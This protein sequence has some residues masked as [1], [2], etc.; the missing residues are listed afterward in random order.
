MADLGQ[1]YVQIVPSAEGISGSI[2]DVLSPEAKKAG[3]SAGK[4]V[5][6][7]LGGT[8]S[9]VGSGMS[10]YVTAPLAGVGAA[11]VA[12]F[13]DVHTGLENIITKTGA[14]GETLEGMRGIMSNLATEIPTDFNTIGNAIGEVNTR[15]GSTGEELETLSGQFIKFADLNGVDVSNAI[16]SVQ[17][18]MA[19]FGLDVQDTGAFLDTLNKVG[20][21]TGVSVTQLASDLMTNAA[22]LKDMG[23]SASDAANFIGNLNKNGIDSST[24]MSGLKKAFS[25]AAAEGKPMSSVLGELQTAMQNAETDTEAYQAAL[26]LFGNRAGPAIA[27]ACRSGRLSF[28]ELGTSITDN[29]GNIETTFDSTLTPM[30]TFKTTMNTLKDT[31]AELGTNL[32]TTLQPAIQTIADVIAKVSEKWQSL[33]PET[34]DAIVKAALIVAAIGPVIAIIGQVI[35]VITTVKTAVAGISTALSVLSAGP[36]ALIVAGI[37][38][39]IA[40]GVTLYQHWDEVCAWANNLKEKVTEAW[41][42]LKTNVSTAV[43][44]VKNTVSQKWEDMKTKVSTAAE[45]IKTTVSTK[46]NAVKDTVTKTMESTRGTVQTKLNAIKTAYEQNGGGIKGIVA[47]ALEAVHQNFKTKYDIINKLTGGRLDDVKKAFEEKLTAAKNTV[48]TIFGNIK[49]AIET[50]INNARDAVKGA[51]DKIKGFF[52]FEWSLPKLKL[53]HFSISGKFSLDPP[54]VPHLNVE[55]YAKG[56]I[57]N[58]TSIIGVGEAGPEAIVPLSGRN[59]RPFAQ[60]V[61][62]EMYGDGNALTQLLSL[63]ATYLPQ[64]ANMQV[65]TDTGALVGAIAPQ[66]DRELGNLQK[67]RGRMR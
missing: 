65:V 50:K 38:A 8:M 26:D 43:E 40:I 55:W 58:D 52:N 62:D 37:A 41:N 51:I 35:S 21:D 4:N 33:S 61:A 19:A 14:S 48:E 13:S 16:D 6:Q 67:Q 27:E 46:W 56:G 1:A 54:S 20:Q 63:V 22:S 29:V 28:D 9:S 39:V 34:Q 44:N 66:M 30:D 42:T 49:S 32:L 11:A 57:I 17:S 18:A 2:E 59:M 60:A 36:L 25:E 10:K 31:G 64:M 15:F 12:A 7:S 53:P 23:F 47:G 5:M 3:A 24:V 45:N